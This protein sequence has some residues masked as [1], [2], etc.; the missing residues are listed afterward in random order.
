[1]SDYRHN[2]KKFA[3]TGLQLR[4]PVD[5]VPATQYSRLTNALPVIE[6]ELRTRNGLTFIANVTEVAF[7]QSLFTQS[8]VLVHVVG[9]NTTY[10]H[11]FFVGD[12]VVIDIAAIAPGELSSVTLGS[13]IVTVTS[14]P[15]AQSFVFDP[16]IPA[17]LV[18]S[19]IA[20]LAMATA[21]N[22]LN[23]LVN[24]QIDNIFRLNQAVASLTGDRI[25]TMEGRIFYAPLPDGNVFRELVGPY[26]PGGQPPSQTM[27]FSGR[28]M[29]IIEFRF[30]KDTA[31]WAIFADENQMFKFRPGTDDTQL[32][33]AQLGN[34]PPVDPATYSAG[35]VGNLNSTGGTGY[36]WRYTYLDGYA[37][38]ESNPSPINMSAGGT[39]TT[40][41]T[42]WTNPATAGNVAFANPANAIDGSGTTVSTGTANASS[43]DTLV[44]KTV[45]CKWQGWAQPAGIVDA[46]TVNVKAGLT[47]SAT[48]EQ[49]TSASAQAFLEYTF[50][51]GASWHTLK[52]ASCTASPLQGFASFNTGIQTYST[53]L[54]SSA[55]F[56]NFAVRARGIAQAR[57]FLVSGLDYDASSSVSLSIYDINTSVT[58][59]GTVNALALVNQSAVVCVTPSPYPQHK[60]IN[61]YRR[62]GSLPDNWRLVG[63]FQQ[64]TLVQGACGAGTVEIDDNVSDT[65]LSTQLIL[66]LDNDQPVTS[67]NKL[68]QPLS[69]IWGPVG[70]EARLLG[71]GDPARPES[72]YFSKPGNADAWPPQNFVEVSSPGTPIIAG[73]VFNTRTFAF[74]RESIY[75]LVEGLGTGSTFTPFRTPSAHGLF[76]PWGL[77][78]G[79]VMY[80]I[81]KDGIYATDGG[82]EQSIVEND[83]KPI[84]PTYDTPGE[85]VE[86]YE[87]V[88]YS[89]PD[90]M[91]LRYHNDE[92][93]FGYMGLTTGT[94]QVLIYDILKKRWRA[95]QATAG[96]TEIYSEPNTVSSLLYGSSAG[97]LYQASGDFDPTDLDII[98]NM[99][100]TS[101]NVASSFPVETLYVRAVRYTA[102]GAVAL[103][104]EYSVDV[105]PTAGIQATFPNAPSGTTKWRVYYGTIP[106]GENQ[107]QEFTEASLAVSRTVTITT[108][109]TNNTLPNVNDNSRI[110]VILRTGADDQGAP[111]N[112]KQY[113]NVIVDLDPGGATVA[114]PVT[115]TP[116]I[117]GEAQAEAAIQ[118]TGVGR[119][120]VPLDLSDFFAFNVEYQVE[121]Q[122]TDVGGGV[123]TNPVLYQYDTLHFIEP[124]G[125]QHWEAQP[126]SFAFP[127]FMHVR[128]AYIAIR[129]N[130]SATLTLTMDTGIGTPIIQTY[131]LPSTGGLREKLYIQFAANK[132]LTYKLAVDSEQEFR[133]YQSDLEVR[134]K[135]WLGVLG[136]SVQRTLGGEVNA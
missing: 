44:T 72:V 69:F 122:R 113:G 54:P 13:F 64:S 57:G 38:T 50:D 105:S 11:G 60:F 36:D 109:G 132:A 63:Q 17:T 89:L 129:S 20:V 29:S 3:D 4:L 128:D 110:A 108:A 55:A 93:Y 23:A 68:N 102:I 2:L 136:Y 114:A 135:P 8:L 47:G 81:A 82:I 6:G 43:P 66:E 31:S 56:A 100:I 112:R 96:I 133:L 33:M 99:S 59:E 123:V 83:I 25:V 79:P 37:L 121:W 74:S 18:S 70:L 32:E 85:D 90:A 15:D 91:R 120:Q 61:L 87:A 58:Q 92:L 27:G 62:G 111:L 21:A 118:V 22:A 10:A 115:I 80:F 127:G 35:G 131:T 42:T 19:G 7:I 73:C 94:R 45:S 53:T 101:A 1:M 49:H 26:A 107:F 104:W 116:Y 5:L 106:G 40:R 134:V 78:I 75:E 67:V 9:A 16:P 97:M 124:V 65:T 86:G 126:T 125:V 76:T 34:A 28:P 130:A 88:D 12:T 103:S 98:E 95:M 39:S 14:V 52:T 51:S 48:A 77:A 71:C 24:T 84:F 119:Q 30:T 46:V 117:D 41:P